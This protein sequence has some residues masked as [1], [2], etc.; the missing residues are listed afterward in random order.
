MLRKV[1]PIVLGIGLLTAALA[2]AVSAWTASNLTTLCVEEDR[3][4]NYDYEDT[5]DPSDNE[6]CDWPV[7]MVFW[8]DADVERVKSHYSNQGWTN[9]LHSPMSGRL[10]DGDG[11]GWEWV[12]DEG[13]KTWGNVMTCHMRVYAPESEDEDGVYQMYNDAWGY[14]VLGTT[15][16]D[17]NEY[18][19]WYAEYGWSED[20]EAEACDDANPWPVFR[21]WTDFCN[22]EDERWEEE[23]FWQSSGE[24][25]SVKVPVD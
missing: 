8:N 6:N 12:S 20:A 9:P 15:H 10:D 24:A 23:H 1:V 18:D 4:K 17:R 7:T 16:Y 5:S 21:N 2:P 11:D 25:S 19:P 14:Y 22:Q 3:F 13:V